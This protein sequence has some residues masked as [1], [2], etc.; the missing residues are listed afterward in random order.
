MSLY[1]IYELPTWIAFIIIVLGF[2]SL[3]LLGH[4]FFKPFAKQWWEH[5]HDNNELNSFFLSGISMFYGITL[6]LIAVGTW[7]NYQSV[8]EAATQESASLAALYRDCKSL[9]EPISDSLTSTLRT[10]TDY[11]IEEAWPMQKRGLIPTGGTDYI[12]AFQQKLYSFEPKTKREEILFQEA[13]KQFN[14][15]VELRR[16][17]LASIT[18]GIPSV[19]WTVVLLG[20]LI[21]M[22]GSWLFI[23]ETK[24][25]GIVLNTLFSITIGI[26]VFSIIMLDNPFMGEV[27]VS[28]EAFELVRDQLML[29]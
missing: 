12:D 11:V 10:Y 4:V 20:A 8:D 14:R 2:T 1:W 29:E 7:E 9:P 22:M 19:L 26:M 24:K 13:L 3:S 28:S 17:R 27:S 5:K 6:G 23:P 21:N 18:S 15:F 16:L 25:Q